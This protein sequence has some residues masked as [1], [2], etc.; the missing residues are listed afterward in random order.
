MYFSNLENITIINI[1]TLVENNIVENKYLEYKKELGNRDSFLAEVCAFAN[2]SG[3]DLIYGIEEDSEGYPVSVIGLEIDSLDQQI[4][5]I[6]NWVNSGIEP[7]IPNIET[8]YLELSNNRYVLIIRVVKSWNSPHRV[9]SS[10]QFYGRTSSGKYPLDVTEIRSAITSSSS[11]KEKINNFRRERIIKITACDTYVPMNNGA[12]VT[13]HLIPLSSFGS[14][15]IISIPNQRRQLQNFWPLGS[16]SRMNYKINLEGH[17]SYSGGLRENSYS[18]VQIYRSGS[19]EAS[20]SFSHY[21]DKKIIL[22]QHIEHEL[23]KKTRDYINQL[24][25]L[26]VSLPMLAFISFTGIKGYKLDFPRHEVEQNL[27]SEQDVILLPEI[28][29]ESQDIDFKSEIKPSIDVF[30]NA[31]GFSEAFEQG[32]D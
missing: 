4:Q 27:P 31:F 20:H 23:V 12:K 3:G 28:V 32:E 14:Q 10:R 30:Y 24:V 26:G 5:K 22:I 29:I 8:K 19:I 1:D 21:N 25:D 18:Y 16:T 7:R 13:L 9:I 17:I 15:D 2:T 6:N 11:L